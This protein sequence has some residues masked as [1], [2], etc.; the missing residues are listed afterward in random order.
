MDTAAE[1]IGVNT[2]TLRRFRNGEDMIPDWLS[3]H[4]GFRRET[5]WVPIG[6]PVGVVTTGKTA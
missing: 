2:R 4:L 6:G 5:T 3:E 1:H